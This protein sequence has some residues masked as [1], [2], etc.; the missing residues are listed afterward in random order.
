MQEKLFLAIF[1]LAFFNKPISEGSESG[2]SSDNETG[3]PCP[4]YFY[5]FFD[6]YN[7]KR[8]AFCRSDSSDSSNQSETDLFSE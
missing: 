2:D 8:N 7:R 3:V 6:T 4:K 5:L 1:T